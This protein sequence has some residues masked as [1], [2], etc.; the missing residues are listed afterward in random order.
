L[1]KGKVEVDFCIFE[2]ME[3]NT[4][5]AFWRGFR[6]GLSAPFSLFITEGERE[7]LRLR[8]VKTKIGGWES[9]WAKLN[10]DMRR[11]MGYAIRVAK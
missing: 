8:R 3:G 6:K 2:I 11:A 10:G 7:S 4:K 9:D 5:S 1:V